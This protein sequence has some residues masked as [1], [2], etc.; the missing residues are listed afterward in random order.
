[1]RR[2]WDPEQIAAALAR[3]P[4]GPPA[5]AERQA[6]VAALLRLG[7]SPSVLLMRRAELAGD[8]WSGHVSLPGGRAEPGDADLRATAVREA[9]EELGIDLGAHAQLLGSLPPIPA[10]ARGKILPMRISAFVFVEHRAVE[11]RPSAEATAAFW[12]PLDRVVAGA[13][14]DTFEY[15]FAQPPLRLPCWTYQGHTVWGLTYR[16]VRSL[17]EEIG[18]LP[19]PG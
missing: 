17:L 5:G 9:A 1:M 11:P 6:A 14:D 18:A 8:P 12:L 15:P 13:L 7:P 10:T 4:Q 19:G 2:A 3:A 16:L